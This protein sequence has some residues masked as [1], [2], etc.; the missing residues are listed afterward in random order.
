MNNQYN[1]GESLQFSVTV[2]APLSFTL[3]MAAR[4]SKAGCVTL[5][6]GNTDGQILCT[7]G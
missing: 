5:T 4:L 7:V 6:L 2:E 3:A 1:Y